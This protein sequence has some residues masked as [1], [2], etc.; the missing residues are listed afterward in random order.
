[1]VTNFH[2]D[3]FNKNKARNR[4]N[5]DI[6]SFN[7]GG[8]AL[9]TFSWYRPTIF[10]D[11][12]RCWG[13]D[14]YQNMTDK[15]AFNIT[16]KAVNAMLREF[17]DLRVIEHLKELNKDE[18]AIAFRIGKD[19]DDFHYCKRAKNGH[20]THKMGGLCIEK[21]TKKEVFAPVWLDGYCGFIVL[22]AKKDLTSPQN[23]GI[24]D[25]Q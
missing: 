22:F 2:D 18:Y 4:N 12:I 5:T 11:N 1:M 6:R 24:I 9:N 17:P 10:G 19:I 14:Y 16:L 23:C 13:D 15:Q 7:C 8:W 20:W 3:G 25:I 21:I